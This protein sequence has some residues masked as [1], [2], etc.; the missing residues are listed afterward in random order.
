MVVD[1]IHWAETTFLELIVHL[2]DAIEGSPVLLLCSSRH[3]LLESHP[4]WALDEQSL[5]LVLRPLTD[6]DSAQ[7]VGGLLGGMGIAEDVRSRIVQAAAGNPLFVEQLLSMLIDNGTL[8]R[9]GGQWEPVGDLARLDV[10]PSIHALL[11]ARLDLLGVAER[12]VIEPASVI[13]QIFAQAAVA[14]LVPPPVSPD[15][16]EYLTALTRKQLVEPNPEPNADEIDYRFEH[17]L[18]RDAAYDGL[19]KRAR[20]DLHERFVDW[21]EEINI[22]QGRVQEFEEIQGYHLEQ[23]Y[24]YLTELGT[25]DAHARDLGA[26][27]STK[28]ASAGRRAMARGDMPA[29]V[30]LLRRAAATLPTRSLEHAALL[31]NL[32]ESLMEVG[33]FDEAQAVL[34]EAIDL[35]GALGDEGLGAEA[36]MI[37]LLVERNEGESPDWSTRVAQ[38]VERALPI[39]ER[40]GNQAGL[41]LGWRVRY[42]L[43]GT[44]GRYGEAAEAAE[45]VIE[46]A[47]GANDP[48]LRARGAAGYAVSALYGPA[49]VSEAIQHCEQLAEQSSGDKRT[50]ALIRSA[51]AQLYAMRGDFAHARDCYRDARASLEDLGIGILA[52][53]TSTDS[54]RVEILADDL[55]AAWRELERDYLRLG[56]LGEAFLR[57]TIGGLLGRVAYAQDRLEDAYQLTVEVE[58]AAAADDVDAQALWRSVRACILARRG[59]AAEAR[60]LAL[61]AVEMR[62]QMDSPALQAEALTDLAEVERWAGNTAAAATALSEAT[63]LYARKGDTVS[64]IKLAGRSPAGQR[65]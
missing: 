1:D 22:Q 37:R 7:V 13:G 19:L 16:P 17:V 25:L 46:H 61:E 35:A 47:G 11:A 53:A 50:E 64:P 31:P 60:R 41:A 28:L 44:A 6:A 3:D 15:V 9:E 38:E 48:R 39:F 57:S 45:Q 23:A 49:P 34:A 12:S 63:E 4:E 24:R 10:P 30:S 14:V 62:R 27:A 58:A 26:R 18:V 32:A 5:R 33:E 51:L 59:E 21:A 20:A 55:D 54:G 43:L 36:G 65:P 56:E 8:R 29:A 2:V 42:A 40:A 52:A